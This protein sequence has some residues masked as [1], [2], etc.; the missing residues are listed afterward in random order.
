MLVGYR[1]IESCSSK[2]HTVSLSSQGAQ[3]QAVIG[4]SLSVMKENLFT[5]LSVNC[6]STISPS[7]S[8]P[9]QTC[10]C[11]TL[12]L[13]QPSLQVLSRRRE[14]LSHS[15]TPDQ[16]VVVPL[17]SV[18]RDLVTRVEDL[19]MNQVILLPEEQQL[20]MVLS[21]TAWFSVSH[22][23]TK[24]VQLEM[25]VS[26][27]VDMASQKQMPAN[28]IISGSRLHLGHTVVRVEG[29][30]EVMGEVFTD[31]IESMEPAPASVFPVSGIMEVFQAEER[32]GED[33][34]NRGKIV[35]KT[36]DHDDQVVWDISNL[37]SEGGDVEKKPGPSSVRFFSI[38]S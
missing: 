1:L 33:S 16:Q 36:Q 11:L 4:E 22:G 23:K 10:L 21:T 31:K 5:N 9:R 26:Q 37:I 3:L 14:L 7:K 2:K 17:T 8:F 6:D 30:R 34:I 25:M 12:T 13:C 15:N 18:A 19:K 32:E 20:A 29:L 27:G 38:N 35:S 28:V 24:V